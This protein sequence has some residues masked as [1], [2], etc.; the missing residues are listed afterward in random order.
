MWWILL[1]IDMTW[2]RL[3]EEEEEEWIG[4]SRRRKRKGRGEGKGLKA[5]EAFFVRLFHAKT[6]AASSRTYFLFG[7]SPHATR[8]SDRDVYR[9]GDVRS[10]RSLPVT[11]SPMTA[12]RKGPRTHGIE[13]CQIRSKPDPDRIWP[14]RTRTLAHWSTCVRWPLSEPR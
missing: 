10:T 3:M 11:L 9:H 13:R 12:P 1:Y 14:S 8:H 7:G 5:L 6:C 4:R 2:C